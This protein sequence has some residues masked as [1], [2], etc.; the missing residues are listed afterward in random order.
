MNVYDP[1]EIIPSRLELFKGP[2]WTREIILNAFKY[3]EI[4]NGDLNNYEEILT[5]PINSTPNCS[6]DGQNLI[7]LRYLIRVNLYLLI[8]YNIFDL[9]FILFF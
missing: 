4:F 3:R 2:T 5:V 7:T 6:I 1:N 8:M 9:K